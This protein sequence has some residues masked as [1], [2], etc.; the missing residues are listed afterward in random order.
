M[1]QYKEAMEVQ[2]FQGAIKFA[3][4]VQFPKNSEF[5]ELFSYWVKRMGEGGILDALQDSSL[6]GGAS[7]TNVPDGSASS[8]V[9]IGFESLVF[10]VGCLVFGICIG[11]GI[12]LVEKIVKKTKA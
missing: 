7:A 10:P 6:L 4:G 2:S 5:S 8:A 12:L 9:A 1:G 3:L 11:L